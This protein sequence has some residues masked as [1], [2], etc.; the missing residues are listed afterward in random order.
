MSLLLN[1]EENV[2]VEKISYP[3]GVEVETLKSHRAEKNIMMVLT[4]VILVACICITVYVGDK[5]LKNIPIVGNNMEQSQ[6]MQ[7]PMGNTPP[8]M[9]EGMENGMT[10]PDMPDGMEN[11][12]TPPD[13]PDGMENGMTRPDMPEG[14]EN[15]ATNGSLKTI[16][17]V[18]FGIESLLLSGI[19]IYILMS[20]F[21]ERYYKQTLGNSSSMLLY[22]L[23]VLVQTGVLT[24]VEYLITTKV[25]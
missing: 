20:N 14:M 6:G 15:T 3:N 17:I 19:A 5:S 18:L 13:M 2:N 16:Y 21:N 10:P 7:S 8:D 25:L 9:P 12:M 24:V 23:A 1:M 11:G 4:C 22:L